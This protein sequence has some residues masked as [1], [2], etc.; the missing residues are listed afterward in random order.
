ME[1]TADGRGGSVT[2][3]LEAVAQRAVA[4]LPDGARARAKRGKQQLVRLR[5]RARWGN[6][7]RRAPFSDTYGLE[8]GRP[9]DRVYIERFL[10][11]RAA[12]VRGAALEVKDATYT[13]RFGGPR[14]TSSDVL[15]LDATNRHATLLADLGAEGAL[16]TDRFD[17]VICTQTLHL[18]PD[19]G[20]A[21]RNLWGSL[22]PGGTLLVTVPTA[23][24]IETS[25]EHAADLWR[26]TPAGFEHVVRTALP[27]EAEVELTGVGNLV[28]LLA[29]LMGLAAE[30]LDD[31]AFDDDDPTYPLIVAARIVRPAG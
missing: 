29:F 4:R 25:Y 28:T 14:V 19:V 23:S 15:D 6:L 24:R 18:I 31:D 17:T 16:P 3:K 13:R 8:R 11:D 26:Y 12:D 9:V 27:G 7:P 1:P 5:N 21:L 2:G 22:R 10:A 30:D 20:V